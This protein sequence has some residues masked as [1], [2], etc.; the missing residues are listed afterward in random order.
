MSAD[1]EPA[2]AEPTPVEAA[3]GR[4]MDA[5]YA[6]CGDPDDPEA[7]SNADAALHALDQLLA[8]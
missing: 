6:V 3:Q 5:F 4:L 7:A 1:E 2:A 8:A